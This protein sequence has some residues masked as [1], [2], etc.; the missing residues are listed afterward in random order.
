MG[1]FA[2]RSPYRPNPLGLTLVKLEQVQKKENETLLLVSGA[3][4]MNGTPIYD[5]KP[6]LPYADVAQDAKAGYATNAPERKLSV[7]F[8][9]DIPKNLSPAYL[10]ELTS[11]LS[12]DPRPAYHTDETRTYGLT[13]GAYDVKF[14]VQNETAVVLAFLPTQN[15]N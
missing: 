2:T 4:L 9:T 8:Q 1:V 3:D 11:V 6:Y 5:I 15:S 12:Y 7:L 10:E 13:F 14:T